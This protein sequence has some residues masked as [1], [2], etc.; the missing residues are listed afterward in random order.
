[1]A[2]LTKTYENCYRG[3]EINNSYGGCYE[4]I[5]DPIVQTFESMWRLCSK[6]LFVCHY[7]IRFKPEFENRSNAILRDALHSWRSYMIQRRIRAEYI[8]CREAG[9]DSL[10]G[11]SHY[12]LITVVSGKYIQ[13][14]HGIAKHLNDLL[15]D[16]T[17]EKSC[18]VHINRPGSGDFNWGKKV[19]EKDCPL[20]DAINWAS[21][22]A[23]CDSKSAP[24]H[25][26]CFCHSKGM[27][28]ACA[29]QRHPSDAE[30]VDFED[31]DPG[32]GCSPGVDLRRVLNFDPA[33][34]MAF[35]REEG[36]SFAQDVP[37]G[38]RRGGRC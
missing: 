20:A 2:R 25:Q 27:F 38:I 13:S 36:V 22:L 21:Y 7:T 8:W 34:G 4:E 24:K 12:H 16:G 11:V 26:R 23:K 18:K 6:R 32:F 15:S 29:K 5:L 3:Y 28:G 33:T 30:I 9:P 35:L 19:S 14:A 31:D 37:A 10:Q 17:G 1:M